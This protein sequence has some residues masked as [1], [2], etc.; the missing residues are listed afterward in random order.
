MPR[1]HRRALTNLAAGMVVGAAVFVVADAVRPRPGLARIIDWEEIR[2]RAHSHLDRAD[3]LDA[4]RVA[5]LEASYHA[6]AE[7]LE[8]P[9]LEF[10]GTMKV[11]FPPFQALD[12]HG[13]VDL[14]IDIMADALQPIV[15]M[16]RR[17]PNSRAVE[18]GRRLLDRYVGLII[19]FLSNRV[20][21][22]YDPHLLG[23]EPAAAPGL[24]LVE[25]NI[26]RWEE[27]SRLPGDALRRWL[28]L[29]EMTHA[30]Q[31]QAHPW[32]RD[33]L[34]DMIRDVIGAA[35]D[36]EQAPIERVLSLTTGIR[37][38][39]AVV[40]RVQAA[41]TLIEGYSNLVMDRVGR[42]VLA[43]FEL[44]EAA[45]EARASNKSVFERLFWK[46]T[47]LELKLQQYVVGERFCKEIHDHY[48]IELLN[49]AWSDPASLP[50]LEE[51][52]EPQA[53]AKRM[54][55]A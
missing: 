54:T 50:T 17:I 44:L 16:Q 45:H 18:M 39:L 51:L 33:H 8:P 1:K 9:L 4:V 19:G 43:D 37:R 27:E 30:W 7:E 29:H 46:V 25:P 38:Q 36:R 28:I 2:A 14:N 12:R 23:H 52:R 49:R 5:S 34:N 35:L 40:S 22:Q 26:N 10:V 53:W 55:A 31:F 32:L 41:M 3:A 42:E 48:G 24:Y 13:W 6:M 20:L 11:D 47:G 15:D 21:G